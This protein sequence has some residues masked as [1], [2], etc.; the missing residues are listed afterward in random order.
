MLAR[1]SSAGARRSRRPERRRPLALIPLVLAIVVLGSGEECTSRRIVARVATAVQADGSVDREVRLSGATSDKA[2]PLDPAWWRN[3]A[4]IELAGRAGWARV[5][6]GPGWIVARG[7]FKDATEV[8]APVGHVLPQG[9]AA[10][11]D[12]ILLERR[13]LVLLTHFVYHEEYGD[14]FDESARAGALGRA[15]DRAAALVDGILRRHFGAG[16]DLS[17]VDAFVRRD[18]QALAAEARK[19]GDLDLP[20]EAFT[21]LGLPSLPEKVPVDTLDKPIAAP[22]EW[23][24]CERLAERLA[25]R[26]TPAD[27]RDVHR[28]F[29]DYFAAQGVATGSGA[30][31]AELEG[32]FDLLSV[33][34]WGVYGEPGR[35]TTIRFEW[36]LTL[37][38]RLLRTNGVPDGDGAVWSFPDDRLAAEDRLMTAESVLLRREPL[39]ALG[40]RAKYDAVETERLVELLTRATAE[41]RTRGFLQRAVEAGDLRALRAVPQDKGEFPTDLFAELADLLDPATPPPPGP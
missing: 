17:A 1:T 8:P 35:S 41:V 39:R 34:L 38:G 18:L 28:A 9:E 14:P 37:P 22:E 7:R 30:P 24:I 36:R 26:G 3:Q 25:A 31:G 2:E 29:Q 27:P 20:A 19:R 33:Y 16:I 13:D 5:E 21:A 12:A 4:G 10:D 40:A 23:W 15:T 32:A 11:R 6:E